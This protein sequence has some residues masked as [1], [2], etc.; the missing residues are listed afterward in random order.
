MKITKKDNGNLVGVF[1]SNINI[2]N[3]VSNTSIGTK[4]SEMELF[5]DDDGT[6]SMIEWVVEDDEEIVE[7]IGL[8]FD[9]KD[10]DDYDGVFEL[11]KEAILLIKESGYNVS[12]DFE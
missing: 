1:T 12:E 7:H 8:S 2:D 11:P 10:L 9:G 5:I 6:P 3:G 4:T